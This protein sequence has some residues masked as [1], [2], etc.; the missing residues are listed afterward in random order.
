MTREI[1]KAIPD[2]PEYK[3]SNHARV[4]RVVPSKKNYWNNHILSPGRAGPMGYKYVHLH[5]DRKQY[6]HYIHALMLQAFRGPRPSPEYDASHE[7]GDHLN[8]VLSNLKWRT[9]KENNALKMKH[10][11]HPFGSKH[12]NSKLTKRQV[13]KIRALHGKMTQREIGKI[14][15]LDQ[16]YVSLVQLRKRRKY[17]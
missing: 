6:T 16:A 10:G 13:H 5:R 1:W 2:W 8:N 12:V 3:V 7:D 14:F 9:K 11:T 17:D 15:D 4:K